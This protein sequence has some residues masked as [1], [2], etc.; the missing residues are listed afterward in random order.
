MSEELI[1]LSLSQARHLLHNGDI[2][3]LELTRAHL[4]RIQQVDEKLNSF[5]TITAEEAL[6]SA[7]HADQLAK[8]GQPSGALHGIPLALKDLYET[9]GVRTTAGL[10]FFVDNI[11]VSDAFTVHR[12]KQAGAILLGKLNMHE[13]ALGTTNIQSYF[14]AC[15]NPW[16]L[17]RS[18]GG[19][20]GGSGA[21]LAAG[22]CMGSLGSDTGGSIR[23]PSSICGV[24][25]LKPT[26]GRV[27]LGGVIPLSW[28]LDHAGPLARHVQDV[29]ILLQVIAGYDPGDPYSVDCPVDDYL[30]SI[31]KGVG[32]WRVA[33]ADDEFFNEADPE[34]LDCVR[35]AA[36]QF[37]DLG[38]QVES[39]LFP[40]ARQAA[41]ANG[42]MTMSDAVAFHHE[43]I[44]QN[45]TGFSPETMNRLL[46]GKNTS[47]QDY[48]QARRTQS[49]ARRQFA[50]F[51]ERYDLLL[52]PTTPVIAP[53]LTGQDA[54]SMARLL[55][56]FTAPFN[57]SG[58]PAISVPCGFTQAGLPVGLQI[59]GPPWA[60]GRLLRAAFAYEQ[61]TGWGQRK[62]A[63]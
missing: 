32:G 35:Q 49:Q 41:V 7:Q 53:P 55:T 46:I 23:I 2:S 3:A 50:E 37:S 26:R 30:E 27:S 29:A 14:G 63:L 8:T 58:L 60:E 25:G 33:L 57:L 52:T 44:E 31:E 17:H 12:L 36:R 62:P 21:A 11:P 9:S 18:P 59:V 40:G 56:R 61:A 34:V 54:T 45:P 51:F 1:W 43:R 4:E 24:V 19:S 5:I 15:H 10:S 22:L 13:I 48:I 6:A 47:L 16:D 42:L 39:T 28:H 20:S 38:A